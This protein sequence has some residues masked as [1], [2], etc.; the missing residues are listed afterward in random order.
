M[1]ETTHSQLE[2]SPSS[3][4]ASEA[5]PEAGHHG[6]EHDSN[7]NRCFF[8]YRC[9]LTRQHPFPSRHFFACRP[10]SCP[11]RCV[12]PNKIFSCCQ[13]LHSHERCVLSKLESLLQLTSLFS[14]SGAYNSHQLRLCFVTIQGLYFLSVVTDYSQFETGWNHLCRAIRDPKPVSLH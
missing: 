8:A 13:R 3:P 1:E 2:H 11:C 7:I 6:L 12:P 9:F 14:G 5:V 4:K 10:T